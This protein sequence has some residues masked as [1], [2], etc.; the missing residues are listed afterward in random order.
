MKKHRISALAVL[1]ALGCGAEGVGNQDDAWWMQQIDI[2]SANSVWQAKDAVF[3]RDLEPESLGEAFEEDDEFGDDLWANAGEFGYECEDADDCLSGLCMDSGTAFLCS[4]S[5]VEECPAGWHCQKLVVADSLGATAY[6]VP[7][8]VPYCRPCQAN[9]D[10]ERYQGDVQSTCY[11][12]AKSNGRFC[13]TECETNLDC[14]EGSMCGDG[15]CRPSSGECDCTGAA[16]NI[17]FL[18][19]CSAANEHGS[20]DGQRSCTEDGLTKC[21]APVPEAE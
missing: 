17:G 19:G 1:I 6:C 5:C 18:T 9:A 20:C 15:V 7:N 13:T 12:L 11:Y 14:A 4:A 21:D 8:F 3:A 10:C 2:P 16:T